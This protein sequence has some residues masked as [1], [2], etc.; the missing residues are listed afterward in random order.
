[1][2]CSRYV[3]ALLATLLFLPAAAQDISNP[4]TNQ[5]ALTQNKGQL[6][7]TTANDDATVGNVGEYLFA[8]GAAPSTNPG[9]T[10]TIASPAVITY[11]SHGLSN[12]GSSPVVFTTTGALPTGIVSGTTYWTVP[13]TVTASTFQIA[14]SIVNAFAG[15][16]INTSGTQSGTHTG[17]QSI[18][19]T[20]ATSSDF[21]AIRLTAGDWQVGGSVSFALGTTTTVVY[22]GGWT[23]TV[24]STADLIPGRIYI[25]NFSNAGTALGNTVNSQFALPARRITVANGATQIIY[26]TQQASFAIS[27]ASG[28]GSVWARRVR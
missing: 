8:G 6:P 19:L 5:S 25:Q 17:N 15:T 18:S 12:T 21:G 2:S 23:N 7:G 9:I 4:Q 1:M 24:S 11:T 20:T 13:G 16:S 10:I 14:T 22:W 3:L 26:G 27:T 28:Y